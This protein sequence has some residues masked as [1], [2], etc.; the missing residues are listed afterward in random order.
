MPA[1]I[2]ASSIYFLTFARQKSYH[3][4][5]QSLLRRR[6][7]PNRVQKQ[8]IYMS[9]STHEERLR[10]VKSILV[11]QPKPADPK[12]PYYT[13]ARKYDIKIDFRPFIQVDPIFC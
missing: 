11:S 7:E 9:N 13:L 12:S 6:K 1:Q 5:L 2:L 4:L 10:E 8:G 3:W